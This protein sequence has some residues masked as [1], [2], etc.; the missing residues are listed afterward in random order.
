VLWKLPLSGHRTHGLSCCRTDPVAI[1]PERTL[2]STDTPLVLPSRLA[3]CWCG[4]AFN[5]S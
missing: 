4:D 3:F 1:D 2:N 5:A